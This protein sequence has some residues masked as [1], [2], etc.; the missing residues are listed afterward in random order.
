MAMNNGLPFNIDTSRKK[1]DVYF[2]VRQG[3]PICAKV[4]EVITSEIERRTSIDVKKI[5]AS[6]VRNVHYR[7]FREVSMDIAGEEITPMLMI[8]NYGWMNGSCDIYVVERKNYDIL[9]ETLTDKVL[10]LSPKI[11]KHIE[12]FP[13]G[14]GMYMT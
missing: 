12:R 3:C 4:E 14:R 9:T 6:F 8:W 5:N 7:F 2:F 11:W 10:A 1:P 13:A